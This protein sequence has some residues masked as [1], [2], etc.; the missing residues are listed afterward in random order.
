MCRARLVSFALALALPVCASGTAQATVIDDLAAYAKNPAKGVVSDFQKA[1][2]N[3]IAQGEAAG[4]G[5]ISHAGME[6]D[7]ASRS[8]ILG[9]GADIDKNVEN[10]TQGEQAILLSLLQLEKKGQQL[11]DQAY[12]LKDTTV[13]D[14]TSWESGWIFA[15]TPDFFVQS[16]RG[17]ALLPQPGDFHVTVTALGFGESS[18][19]KADI[20]ATLNGNPVKFSEIDQV[21]QRGKAVLA[22]PNGVITPLFAPD[23]LKTITLNLNVQLTRKR[24]LF[25]H[26]V[27]NYP[28]PITLLLYP[29]KIATVTVTTTAPKFDWVSVGNTDS[30]ATT[31]DKDGC[32]FCNTNCTAKNTVTV[33]VS[34][35]HTPLV[36]GDEKLVSGSLECRTGDLCAFE[37]FDRRHID[38]I[39]NGSRETATWETC[40]HPAQYVLHAATQQ[41]QRVGDSTVAGTAINLDINT[42]QVVPLPDSVSLVVVDVTSFTKQQY[43]LV[44]PQLDPHSVITA[45]RQPATPNLVITAVPPGS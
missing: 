4:N 13:V 36:V 27:N 16:I 42:P 18:D 10:L 14:L 43:R 24:W 23:Q 8:A 15:H 38:I 17:T 34:G 29:A 22:I 12:D 5:L 41:W 32:K 35:V 45:Q 31:Q 7:A 39:N 26:R 37:A 6:L 40:T 19:S 44:L 30:P 9:L 28:F 11:T 33:D 2:G 3:L 21:S 1:G 20:T 25:G